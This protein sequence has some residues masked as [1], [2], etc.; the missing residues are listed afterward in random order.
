[1]STPV[2][3]TCTEL[4]IYGDRGIILSEPK[5]LSA[6]RQSPAYVLLGD[7][8]SGKTTE[9]KQEAEALGDAAKYLSAR[10]F[11]R[12]H[13]DSN[14]EWRDKTLFIDGLDEMRAGTTD[15]LTP[16]DQIISQLDRLGQPRFRISC[17][18]ADWLGAN[19]RKNLA[20]V[21]P[22]SQLAVLRL[23]PLDDDGIRALLTSLDLSG[24]VQEFIDQA[25]QQGLGAILHNPQTLILLANAVEQGGDWPDSQ[26]E[27]FELACQKMAS[28]WNEEHLERTDFPSSDVTMDAAGYLCALQLLAGTEGYS[29]SRRLD[30]DSYPSVDQLQD[31]PKQI[32]NNGLGQA[33]ATRLF[34]GVAERRVSPLHRHIAEFLAGR[35]L[36]KMIESGLP[37]ERV[38]ALMTSP[39]DQRVVSVLRGLSAWLAAHSPTARRR[40]IDLDPVGVGLYGDIGGLTPGEKEQLLGSL[41]DFAEQGSLF[42]HERHEDGRGSY[43]KS[44]A[45]AFRSLATADMVPTIKELV[46]KPLADSRDERTLVFV[47]DT[48]SEADESDL[49]SLRPLAP[50]LEAI[51]RDD[52]MPPQVKDYALDAFLHI[53]PSGENEE[54]TLLQL[55]HEIQNGALSDPHDQLRGTLLSSLYPSPLSPS[56]VWRYATP[57]NRHNIIGRFSLFL[58]HDLLEDSSA[59]QVAE[60]L[61][62]LYENASGLV[63]ALRKP[64]VDNMPC[65]LLARGLEEC[66]EETD[67][68]RIYRWLSIIAE[69]RYEVHWDGQQLRPI[70]EWL[71]ARPHIQKAIFLDWLRRCNQSD[72]TAVNVSWNCEMLLES[73]LPPDFGLW[74]LGKAVELADM[75][76]T[77]AQDLLDNSYYSLQ[78]PESSNGLSMDSIRARIQRHDALARRLEELCAPPTYDPARSDYQERRQIQIAKQEEEERQRREDWDAQLRLHESELRANR[79]HPP[80]LH[81][82]AREYFGE[83]GR[84]D[85]DASPRQRMGEFIGGDPNLVD[86]VMVALRDAVWRDDIPEAKETILLSLESKHSWLAYPVIASLDLLS[87]EDPA[88]LDQLDETQRR[89]TLAIYFCVF[90]PFANRPNLTTLWFDRWMEQDPESVTEVLFKCAHAA[91][92]AGEQILPGLNEL[93]HI[94]G[95]HPDLAHKLTARLL[96]S[97]PVRA[98][99]DQIPLLDQLLDKLLRAGNSDLEQLVE[100]KLSLSSMNVAQRVRWLAAGTLLSP[101][102]HLT[103]LEDYV[104]KNQTRV[105]HLAEFLCYRARKNRF[106]NDALVTNL[107]PQ[108]V[109]V[110]IRLM[111]ST[112]QPTELYGRGSVPPGSEVSRLIQDL[113]SLLGA[114]ASHQANTALRELINNLELSRWRDRLS[115]AE[116]QQR[117]LLR[118]ATYSHSSIEKVQRTLDNGLPANAEDLAALLNYHLA[119]IAKDI[120]GSSSNLWR[121]FWNEKPEL[122]AKHED[123]CRDAL[124]AMLQARRLSGV[125]VAREGHY[126]SGKRAD[127]RVSHGGFNVPIEIK[128]D[129]HRDLWSALQGQLV[130]QYSSTDRATSGYGIYLVLWTGGD[131]IRRKPYGKHPATPD[132]LRELLEGDLKPGQA[133]KISVR[134]LDVTKP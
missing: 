69:S 20:T 110:L 49:D 44:T 19:D 37:V 73:A 112:N 4:D 121:Q 60:L 106:A 48:L 53:T 58:H 11:N 119:D 114:N 65:R 77:V 45:Q 59:E 7:A 34:T 17:R 83:L 126:V 105:R 18:E 115:R 25:K 82:L 52:A 91:M 97:F 28:E 47:L 8:G 134:V 55:L 81:T 46:A 23:D 133:T 12:S 13:A 102:H 38:L 95:T 14:Q 5:P 72:P 128:K 39:S 24:D 124:L 125:D 117:V 9:F 31:P 131:E 70:Q 41:A 43:G 3:R 123:A 120:R 15:S 2:D 118:D 30:N 116:E 99:K 107:S 76:P 103:A 96:S 67:I 1:M 94:E 56:Q 6:F 29:L 64:M 130:D 50:G 100:Q 10:E 36:A 40:L 90:S 68:A 42:G 51:L 87:R 104:G 75:A 111:G 54:R 27:T 89:D 22:D 35:Y 33:L 71:E 84:A 108:A 98:P 85:K 63:P 61:D 74:C 62:A 21:S 113:I 132:E 93:E 92:R 16:L 57:R 79:F 32:S 129:S 101:Q 88:L 109:A 127:I 122:T 66:G 78:L 86:A 26:Q 80:N